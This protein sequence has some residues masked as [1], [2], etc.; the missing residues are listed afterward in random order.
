MRNPGG[1]VLLSGGPAPDLESDTF[2]CGHCNS[3][4]VVPV[5]QAPPGL[6]L[7]CQKHVCVGCL[8]E[9]NRTLKCVPFEKRLDAFERRAQLRRAAATA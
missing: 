7:C 5:G 9:M 1:Y 8:A 4:H 6:C 3:I 2:T